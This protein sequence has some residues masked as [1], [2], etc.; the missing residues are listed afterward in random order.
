[1]YKD[2]RILIGKSGEEEIRIRPSM[3]NRH[4]MLAGA[5]GTGNT[6]TWK[7]IAEFWRKHFLIW[8]CRYSLQM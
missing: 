4:G 5:T 6:I 8:E 3:A 2:G 1:M 7:V